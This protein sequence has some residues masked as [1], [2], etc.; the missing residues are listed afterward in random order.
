M[1]SMTL[2]DLNG[3]DATAFTA[4]LG[5]VF[6]HSPWIAAQAAADRPYADIASLH[7][8]MCRQVEQADHAAQLTLIRAHPELAGKAALR[9]ELTVESTKEQ[10]G[11]GLNLCSAE[12]F[13]KLHALNHAYNQKF[14]FPFIVAVR[15]HTRNSILELMERRL[16][17][18]S[19]EEMQQAL[20]QIYQIALFRL[21]ELIEENAT[22]EPRR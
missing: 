15:G 21:Q 19:T 9:G 13:E 20:Q 17:N 2:Y 8:A 16:Q 18:D 6:E 10:Q 4:L 11:A 12:E 14:G 5:G 22:S 1:T 3:A 7:A